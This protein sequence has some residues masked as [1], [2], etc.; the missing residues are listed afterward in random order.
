MTRA[1]ARAELCLHLGV[2][3]ISAPFSAEYV[4]TMLNLFYL[5]AEKI[6][7]YCAFA[8]KSV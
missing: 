2:A 1:T 7:V 6:L 5:F 3:S 8:G 4:V